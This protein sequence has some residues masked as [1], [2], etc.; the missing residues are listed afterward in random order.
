MSGFRAI[1][2]SQSSDTDEPLGGEERPI[3]GVQAVD[4]QVLDEDPAGEADGFCSAPM[5][6][7]R[8]M[9]F[10]PSRFRA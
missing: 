1:A 9:Y 8:S 5:W 10:D 4:L 3:A 2:G 7:G 6:S